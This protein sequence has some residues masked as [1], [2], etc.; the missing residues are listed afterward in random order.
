VT[1]RIPYEFNNLDDLNRW[2][3][4]YGKTRLTKILV[5][6]GLFAGG[7]RESD[8][9][10]EE[11]VYY[12]IG[13]SPKGT[14]NVNF[15]TENHKLPNHAICTTRFIDETGAVLPLTSAIEE[16]GLG[17]D[18]DFKSEKLHMQH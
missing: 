16:S 11:S 2:R 14:L 15:E 17:T 1:L 3:S 10:G 18:Y 9:I 8:R 13:S 7:V 6:C 12:Q 5:N 4:D